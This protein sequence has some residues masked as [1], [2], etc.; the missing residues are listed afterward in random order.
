VPRIAVVPKA[1]ARL[2]AIASPDQAGQP[3]CNAWRLYDTQNA[4]TAT[5]PTLIFFQTV[6][7]DKT[8]SN[9]EG[10]GQLPDPQ[11]YEIAG[12]ECDV[13]SAPVSAA[14]FLGPY[15]DIANLLFTT[16]GIFTFNMSNKRY[17]PWPLT[18][19][20]GTGGPVGVMSNNATPPIFSQAAVNGIF[21]GGFWADKQI[22]I[23]PKIGF[24]TTLN[25]G[26]AVTLNLSPTPIR[27]VLWG[28]LHRRVL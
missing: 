5:T 27:F 24:D 26:A 9:M 3:E 19:A 13:L 21:D 2:I 18:A 6:N 7:V 8:L 23:P 16:R 12:F 14:T 11:F 4:T 22:V 1:R 25:F 10:P 20:H 28:V 15:N 17:G